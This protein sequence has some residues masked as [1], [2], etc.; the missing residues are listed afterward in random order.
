VVLGL[1]SLNHSDQPYSSGILVEERVASELS[2]RLQYEERPNNSLLESNQVSFLL[3]RK[4]PPS[5][6]SMVVA[7]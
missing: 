4:M 1:Q 3:L 6:K 7:Q 2:N 5:E